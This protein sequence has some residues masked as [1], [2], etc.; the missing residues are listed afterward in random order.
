MKS[1]FVALALAQ[2]AFAVAAPPVTKLTTL[3]TFQ[4]TDGSLPLGS[5]VEGEDGVFYGVTESG[6]TRGGGT[7]YKV[8]SAGALTT[9]FNFGQSPDSADGEGPAGRLVRGADGAFYGVTR[10][11]GGDGISGQGVI[12]RMTPA[13]ALTVLHSF[14]GDDGSTQGELTLASDGNFYGVTESGG[15]NGGGTIY[16]MT[17]TGTFTV[18][19]SFSADA[20]EVGTGLSA[21]VEGPGMVLYGTSRTGGYT[22]PDIEGTF[23]SLAPN[24]DFNVR[25]R[26]TLPGWRPTGVVFGADGALYGSTASGSGYRMTTDGTFAQLHHMLGCSCGTPLGGFPASTFFR[27]GD[28]LFYGV[29]THGGVHNWG[30]IYSM[31]DTGA[32]EPAHSF[33][34]TDEGM[35]PV[36]ALIEGRDGRLYGTTSGFNTSGTV[37]KLAFL[38]AAPATLTATSVN[39]GEV[40]LAWAAVRSANSYN[41]Y[42]GTVSGGLDPTPALTG[43]AGTSLIV[44]GLAGGSLQFYAVAAVNEAGI[45]PRSTEAN[46]M[47]AAPPPAL[48]PVPPPSSGGG[49]G[50]AL[51]W[52]LLSTL[53][54]CAGIRLLAPQPR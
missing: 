4:L 45:G 7:I 52:W 26:F 18:L 40:T 22:V 1:L 46:A 39:V 25:H 36:A 32:L 17:P 23:F 20:T 24:G 54:L 37:Y 50:G 30:T 27:R 11:G 49:G 13:G 48:P 41:V 51:D 42:R 19:Y 53:L 2:T 14:A 35:A 31:S 12:F 6:G 9:L 21:L 43:F 16:R 34:G 44:T 8:S 10:S 38:P 28:G 33:N 15:V 5:L 47:V 29:T 3:H